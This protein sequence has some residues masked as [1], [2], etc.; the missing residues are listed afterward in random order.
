MTLS[1]VDSG[2]VDIKHFGA[3]YESGHRRTI[4]FLLSKGIPQDQ[5]VETAQAA[6]V[7]GLERLHQVRDDGKTITWVNSIALNLYRNQIR[8]D[9]K[10]EEPYHLAIRATPNLA[11]IDVI[12]MLASCNSSDRNLLSQRY[13][14]ER[15]IGDIAHDYGC[16]RTAIRVRLF[17]ALRR[18]R[19]QIEPACCACTKQLD[20]Q[21]AIKQ[22]E[23]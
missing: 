16:S 10:W 9:A 20:T 11:S 15:E 7:R 22:I 23:I 18:L 13:L 5:A 12:R 8:R 2:I 19:G 14:Q 1:E 3:A 21:L 17:R 6:W 4:A